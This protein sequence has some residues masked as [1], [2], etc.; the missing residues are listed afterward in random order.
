[1]KLTYNLGGGLPDPSIFPK[2]ISDIHFEP[3]ISFQELDKE[4]LKILNYRGINAK[5]EELLLTTGSIQ[6]IYIFSYSFIDPGDKIAIEYPTFAGAIKV[7]KAR[8][9][10]L[11]KLPVI[12]YYYN[13]EVKEK[14][15]AMYVIPTGQNPTGINMKLEDKKDFLN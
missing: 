5:N 9:P 4:L 1:M 11:V 7:F 13:I 15:K 3:E 8:N 14:I 6:G 2:K 10:D 12:P